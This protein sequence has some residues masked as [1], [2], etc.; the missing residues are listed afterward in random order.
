MHYLHSTIEHLPLIKITKSHTLLKAIKENNATEFRPWQEKWRQC[1]SKVK[2]IFTQVFFVLEE[3]RKFMLMRNKTHCHAVNTHFGKERRGKTS[4]VDVTR[5]TK[6][7]QGNETASYTWRPSVR[8]L[9]HNTK[10]DFQIRSSS[11]LSYT[12]I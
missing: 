10:G 11:F 4:L 9:T 8:L 5:I 6:V 1:F 12:S 2:K 3:G 7:I